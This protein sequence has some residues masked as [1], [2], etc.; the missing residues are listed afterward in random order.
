QSD[1]VVLVDHERNVRRF[2][3]ATGELGLHQRV[4]RRDIDPVGIHASLSSVP[5]SS[6]FGLRGQSRAA[7]TS[8][9]NIF[10]RPSISSRTRLNSSGGR[11][12][13]SGS[14]Q[15]SRR[16]A[17]TYGHSSPQPIVIT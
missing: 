10:T 11:S 17:A 3:P 13:G 8:A 14:S 2:E 12:F 15:S 1:R 7:R 9:I 6:T 16:S 5:W 4:V